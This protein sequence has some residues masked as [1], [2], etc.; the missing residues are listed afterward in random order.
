MVQAFWQCWDISE[1]RIDNGSRFC[2]DCSQP[3]AALVVSKL[4]VRVRHIALQMQ[5]NFA[6]NAFRNLFYCSDSG[7]L[8]LLAWECSHV[9]LGESHDFQ[10]GDP[11]ATVLGQAA[12]QLFVW[13]H[14]AEDA[15]VCGG[16]V[17]GLRAATGIAG[18]AGLELPSLPPLKRGLILD[19]VDVV[20][21]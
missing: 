10:V 2:G 19:A 12:A 1:F 20:Y 8:V 16:D 15:V 5:R 6:F 14:H 21:V 17:F 4:Y 18:A 7:R 11:G 9:R 3:L 13:D